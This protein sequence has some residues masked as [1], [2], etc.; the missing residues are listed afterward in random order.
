M[1]G[2]LA[3]AFRRNE[4]YVVATVIAV[5]F[6]AAMAM[7]GWLLKSSISAVAYEALSRDDLKNVFATAYLRH[8]EDDGKPYLKVELHN[9]TL[10]WIRKITFEFE[11]DSYTVSDPHAFRPLHSGAVRC[12]LRKDPGSSDTREYNLTIAEA[13]GY[14]P[15]S[16]QWG[17]NVGK[18]ARE[19][20]FPVRSTE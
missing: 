19:A 12:P 7:V 13:F 11:D 5:V 20:R 14:P 1:K 16:V 9:G 6:V 8:R 4:I 18:I 3:A 2:E 10:W 17:R 15:A